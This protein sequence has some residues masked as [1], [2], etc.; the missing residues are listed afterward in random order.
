MLFRLARTRW[1]L[2]FGGVGIV[3]GMRGKEIGNEKKRKKSLEFLRGDTESRSL[4]KGLEFKEKRKLG[5]LIQRK[6]KTPFML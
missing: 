6:G 1:R 2:V 4:V 5:I 3:Y